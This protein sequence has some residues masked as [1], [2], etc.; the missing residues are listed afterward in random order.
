MEEPQTISISRPATQTIIPTVEQPTVAKSLYNSEPIGLPSEGFFYEDSNPLSRGVV[1]I[2]YMTAK[3]ED[4]LTSQN[5]IKKGLVLDRLL[6]GLILTSGVK[7][8]DLLVGDKNSLLVAARRLAYGDSYGPLTIKC[9]SCGNECECTVDLGKVVSKPFDFSKYTKG[10]NEFEVVLPLSKK[11]IKYKLLTHKDEGAIDAEL[12][13]LTKLSKTAPSPE[14][15]TRLKYMILS[16]DGE[17]D[18]NV[19]KKFIDTELT[20][21]DS[22]FLRNYVRNNT[23]NIDMSFDFSCENCNHTER[24]DVPLTVQFF[25]PQS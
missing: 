5:L 16:V 6:E 24:M 7:I 8:G 13:A 21:R 17:S 25:W 3:E 12:V 18:R 20:S 10:K 23:P 19:I 9:P 4:I 15:T 14:I 22:L 2:K 1:D 11:S